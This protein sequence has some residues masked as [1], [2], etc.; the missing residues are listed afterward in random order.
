MSCSIALNRS[1]TLETKDYKWQNGKKV[2]VQLWDTAGQEKFFSLSKSSATRINWL[3]CAALGYFQ[4]SHGVAVIFDLTNRESFEKIDD[5]WMEQVKENS[6]QN[7]RCILIGNKEDL[8]AVLITY[9]EPGLIGGSVGKSSSKGGGSSFSWTVW[10]PVLRDK[11]T[12]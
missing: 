1:L 12:P 3:T 7:V 11:V 10:L 4:K 5:F 2:R 8:T 9:P 6:P